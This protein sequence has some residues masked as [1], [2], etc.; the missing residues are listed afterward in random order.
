VRGAELGATGRPGGGDGRA[1]ASL[2]QGDRVRGEHA[3]DEGRRGVAS[4]RA[5]AVGRDVDRVAGP[6]EARDRVAELILGGDLDGEGR[7]GDLRAD[8]AAAGC[9]DLEAIERGRI[10]LQ[11]GDSGLARE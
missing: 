4:A 8:V 9:L 10:D 2:G 3:V 1:R 6:V 7:A 5:D 11:G